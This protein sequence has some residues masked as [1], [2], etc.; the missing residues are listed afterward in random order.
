MPRLCS[1]VVLVA[2]PI[3]LYSTWNEVDCAWPLAVPVP[4][5]AGRG[6]IRPI[7]GVA[8]GSANHWLPS[9]P[10]AISCGLLV[11]LRP[12]LNSTIAC[13]VGL[14]RPIALV[15]PWSLNQRFPSGP[16]AIR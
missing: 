13:V 3:G 7:P 6:V 4:A 16:A 1:V 5:I 8:P 10:A 11:V 9:G 2:P 12:A 15:V 14:I